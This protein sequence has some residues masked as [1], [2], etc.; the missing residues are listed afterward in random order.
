MRATFTLVILTL[1]GACAAAAIA[2]EAPLV[3]VPR[4]T[5]YLNGPSDLARLRQVNPGHYARA[6]R[7]LAA[8]NHLCRPGRGQLQEAAEARDLACDG[9]FLRTSNPP[10]WQI[11]FTLDDTRYVALV[12]VTDDPPRVTPAAR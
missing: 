4:P 12:A 9:S 5:V 6:E 8:A 10:K 3:S 11:T 7:I 2:D 1:T